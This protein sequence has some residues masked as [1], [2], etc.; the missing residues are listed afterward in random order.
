MTP[1]AKARE[2]IDKRLEQ[3]GWIIQDMRQVNPMAALGVAVREYPTSTGPVDYALFVE[4]KPVGVVEAKRD[5]EGENITTVE[6]QSGRYASSTFKYVSVD[7]SI[8][9]AYEATGKLMRFT[10]YDDVK[11]RSRDVFSFH[12]PE[13]LRYL[14]A[15][16]DTVRN[17]LKRLPTLD[18][19][20]FRDCQIK[21]MLCSPQKANDYTY[22]AIF[23]LEIN[24][25]GSGSAKE[26]AYLWKHDK[27]IYGKGH[28]PRPAVFP[29][30]SCTIV[31]EV[32]IAPEDVGDEDSVQLRTLNLTY[33]DLL[34]NTYEQ[35][36]ELSFYVYGEKSY[37]EGTAMRITKCIT[38]PAE[39]K[40]NNEETTNDLHPQTI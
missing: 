40:T 37:R 24:N 16:P 25:I 30:E 4:G 2:A 29:K 15:Q 1:E 20:G 17:N 6:T 22:Y 9:F 38:Y 12:R 8:R 19:T 31:V 39:L 5:D 18:T 11:F 14:L 23:V 36:V 34:N 10:D 32:C 27:E 7:Y 13:T 33:K 21:A 26:I 3:S 28:F 35:K